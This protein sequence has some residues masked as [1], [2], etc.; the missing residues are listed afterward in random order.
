MNAAV[1]NV[2]A[3]ATARSQVEGLQVYGS[4]L[5]LKHSFEHNE[6]SVEI[7]IPSAKLFSEG[8][9][10]GSGDKVSFSSGFAQNPTPETCTYY[11]SEIDISMR[12]SEEVSLPI[13]M[14]QTSLKRPEL[15]GTD[16]ASSLE[17]L[18]LDY[19]RRLSEILG[20][21]ERVVRWISGGNS[22]GLPSMQVGRGTS[23]RL[24]RM[25]LVQHSDQHRF[26]IPTQT[27]AIY[28]GAAIDFEQWDA[29]ERTLRSGDGQ[30][31][32]FRY[33]DVAKQHIRSWRYE[34]ALVACAIAAETLAREVFWLASGADSTS[35]A[36]DILDGVNVR[37][38]ISRWQKLTGIPKSTARL[39][40]I[41][42]LFDLRNAI[43]HVGGTGAKLTREEANAYFSAAS[44]FIFAGD[45]WVYENRGSPNP[46]LY[47]R[48]Q[49]N[50]GKRAHI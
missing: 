4:V 49:N 5:G 39:S 33:M 15:A 17:Q 19:E 12:V 20:H 34:D 2:D 36:R 18:S 40:E 26:W 42:K 29:I 14:L 28:R 25:A 32:W 8:Q 24:K 13:E 45:E 23:T 48:F 41:N 27:M 37:A 10:I 50:T 35:A 3:S 11:V 1:V 7:S 30:P 22:V 6:R 47:A 43:M 38:I 16:L 44:D 9:V 31:I 46:R 21:W